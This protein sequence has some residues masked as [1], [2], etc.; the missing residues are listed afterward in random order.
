MQRRNLAAAVEPVSLQ[1]MG[2]K[3]KEG[4]QAGT[5]RPAQESP[6]AAGL[7]QVEQES[8]GC[9]LVLDG[10]GSPWAQQGQTAAQFIRCSLWKSRSFRYILN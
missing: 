7:E 10:H 8:S 1:G 5:F 9:S 2:M 4:H 6:G 3:Q